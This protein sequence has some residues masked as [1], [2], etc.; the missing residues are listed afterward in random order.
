MS[1]SRIFPW[2][3]GA[4]AIGL[5]AL[6]MSLVDGPAA[7]WGGWIAYAAVLVALA[8]LFF[9]A[10]RL[11][12]RS[13][14]ELS[15]PRWLFLAVLASLALRLGV[16]VFFL[17]GL[18][19][20]GYSESHH[21]AGYFFPDAH[22]R[23]TESWE[24]AS[25]ERPLADAFRGGWQGDQYGGLLAISA[26]MYR[27]LS[28][29]LHRPLLIVLL[30][31]GMG[32]L[33]VLFTWAFVSLT[34]GQAAGKIAAWIM[35]VFPDAILLGATQMREPFMM[36]GLAIALYGYALAR[37]GRSRFG[38][39]TSLAGAGLVFAVSPPYGVLTAGA[40]GFLW[41]WEGRADPRR[42]RWALLGL[43]AIFVLA[44]LA[45]ISSWR[46][47]EGFH[48]PSNPIEMI[49]WW[50]TSGANFEMIKL[51]ETSG[52]A[53]TIFARTPAWSHPLLATSYGL[54][55]PFLPAALADNSGLPLFRIIAIL[56]ATGWFA[57]LPFLVY[58]P[59]AAIRSGGWRGLFVGISLLVWGSAIFLAFRFGGD[60]WDSPRYRT[61]FLSLQAALVGWSWMHARQTSAP[62]LRRVG[63]L[64]LG[65]TA[66]LLAWYL[67]RYYHLPRLTFFQTLAVAG[68]FAGVFLAGCLLR[69]WRRARSPATPA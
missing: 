32:S 5:T 38:L 36:L 15:V 69:D 26:G 33:A 8:G 22:V 21:Q 18:P 45:T 52:W 28:P 48:R 19:S 64:Q 13:S 7:T 2:V 66:I 4:A 29:D 6:L 63:I 53:D 27:W 12:A 61:V 20:L 11:I 60:Q 49:A 65:L 57:L 9:G 14:P 67:G 37:G 50:L 40:V 25:S 56:R 17:R 51:T 24:L 44:L 34:A 10:R 55:Q 16:G 35:V 31:A 62:W 41:V 23:D 42:S 30:A 58:A 3:L 43:V 54:L 47:I 68:G 39:L 59:L 46:Q 1:I